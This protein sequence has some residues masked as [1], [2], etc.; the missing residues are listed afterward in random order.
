MSITAITESNWADILEL[1]Q[2]V[3]LQVA[4]ESLDVLKS[5]WLTSP[6]S[7]LVLY[8]EGML[9]GYL[10]AHSWSQEMPP[11]LFKPLPENCKGSTLFV[12]DLAV[13]KNSTGKGI[14]KRLITH[15]IKIAKLNGYQKIMLVAVQGST[16]F[17]L[18][19]GFMSVNQEVSECYG[20]NAQLMLMSV[21]D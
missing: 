9:M 14:G 11:K 5:K 13:H 7:C 6:E 8:E 17:W 12:H 16:E 20:E 18:K 21:G 4:P 1:Q 10:L 3:Y 19:Q 15:I 2:G